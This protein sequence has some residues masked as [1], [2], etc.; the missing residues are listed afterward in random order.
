L[1]EK[2][3]KKETGERLYCCRVQTEGKTRSTKREQKEHESRL[4]AGLGNREESEEE[5]T[6]RRKNPSLHLSSAKPKN[7][8]REG[9]KNR[10]NERNSY[11]FGGGIL[12]YDRQTAQAEG[13]KKIRKQGGRSVKQD[14]SLNISTRWLP[15]PPKH[16]NTN[17][18]DRRCSDQQ[19]QNIS[20]A[21]NHRKNVCVGLVRRVVGRQTR[22]RGSKKRGH[23]CEP[24]TSD[25]S[26]QKKDR[27]EKSDRKRMVGD[28]KPGDKREERGHLPRR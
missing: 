10:A 25:G 19:G 28:S 2:N 27:R 21:R 1:L 4:L 22:G 11:P 3:E 26:G 8:R 12:R 9:G 14:K 6:C 23:R 17:S 7:S 15:R 20:L 5:D 16:D 24:L 13:F 18:M